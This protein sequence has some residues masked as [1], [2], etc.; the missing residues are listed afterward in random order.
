[1]IETLAVASYRSLRELIVPLGQLN[2]ITEPV[3]VTLKRERWA[4]PAAVYGALMITPAIRLAGA[5][6][7]RPLGRSALAAIMVRR[8]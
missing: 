7:A 1:M 8:V 6:P 2:L 4:A 5:T 3:L